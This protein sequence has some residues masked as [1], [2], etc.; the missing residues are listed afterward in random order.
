M[1]Y[2]RVNTRVDRVSVP[3]LERAWDM[4]LVPYWGVL[5]LPSVG[6]V[7]DLRKLT[8]DLTKAQMNGALVTY[9]PI[10]ASRKYQN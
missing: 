9:T 2:M 10:E 4:R 5:Y 7:V 1:S 8:I 6:W 3:G